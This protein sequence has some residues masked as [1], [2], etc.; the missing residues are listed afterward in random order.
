MAGALIVAGMGHFRHKGRVALVMLVALGTA[1]AGF[2]ISTALLLSCMLLFLAGM[3]LIAVF[4][5][6]S[7]LVQLNTTNEMRGRVMSVYNV[8]FRG[9]MPFGSLTTGW[10][11]PLFS[12]PA[13][14]AVNGLLLVGLAAYFLAVERRVASL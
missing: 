5:T 8:A 9:G 4:A 3:A 7:S 1:I 10:L 11:V 2:A 6:I 12:A 14:L 13:V